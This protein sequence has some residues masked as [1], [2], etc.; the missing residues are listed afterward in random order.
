MKHPL[1]AFAL[2]GAMVPSLSMAVDYAPVSCEAARPYEG[3]ALYAGSVALPSGDFAVA[4]SA[5][6]DATVARLDKAMADA[7]KHTRA[8]GMAQEGRLSPADP[9]SRWAPG[10][11]NGQAI[12][13][14]HLL[15][16]TAGVFS[17]NE[18]VVVRRE[19]RY[20]SADEN[21]AVAARHGPMFCPGQNWRYS[22]TGYEM[23]GKVIEAVEGRPYH[24][25]VQR[26]IA[27]RLQLT[28]LRALAPAEEPA[29]DVVRL[30]PTHSAEP[31]M[32]PSWAN[33]AGNVVASAEDMLQFWQALLGAKLLDKASCSRSRWSS[34]RGPSGGRRCQ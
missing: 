20:R 4:K 12:T 2:A 11:P 18:D 22:N 13:V 15:Q 24:E 14:D 23:L 10:F 25:V 9:I 3:R 34:L 29:A 31:A 19:R 32:V 27:D 26:R 16:H 28:T 30:V 1:F 21:I 8:H 7:M 5:F 17:A 33:A 6:D